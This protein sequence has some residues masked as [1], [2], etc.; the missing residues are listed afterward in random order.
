M[1]SDMRKRDTYIEFL[2][3]QFS[4]LGAVT[5]RA[6]FGGYCLYCDFTV[7]ALV[8]GGALYLKADDAHRDRFI[9]R[10]LKAFKPFADRDEVMSYYEAPPEIFE[11]S[12][13]MRLWVGG[14]VEA[15][16]RGSK[17][18]TGRKCA[19]RLWSFARS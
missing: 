5:A 3:E 11:D 7:F 17:K 8:A 6:M 19:S 13:A 9:A 18:K 16:R 15:G 10:G 4:T 2:Q 1:L 12:D 14:A